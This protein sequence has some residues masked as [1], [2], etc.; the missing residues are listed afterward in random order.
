MRGEDVEEN[1]EYLQSMHNFTVVRRPYCCELQL[2]NIVFAR[3]QEDPE[4]Q[5]LKTDFYPGYAVEE[6]DMAAAI[7]VFSTLARFSRTNREKEIESAL[8]YVAGKA[9]KWR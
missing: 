5:L 9:S 6:E 7:K 2:G 1:Y 4:T 8:N 3:I